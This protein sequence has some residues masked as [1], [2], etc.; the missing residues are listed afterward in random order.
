VFYVD[1]PISTFLINFSVQGSFF[2][3]CCLQ[4]RGNIGLK[5]EGL[6]MK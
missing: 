6:L 5:S 3:M 4:S 2:I 1:F